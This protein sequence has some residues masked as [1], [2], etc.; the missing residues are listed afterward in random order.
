MDDFLVFIVYEPDPS[1]DNK[2]ERLCALQAEKDLL[3]VQNK[4]LSPKK[5]WA[6]WVLARDLGNKEE[7]RDQ[8]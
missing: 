3:K 1:Y 8:D 2:R 5:A 6:Y 7:S 4:E